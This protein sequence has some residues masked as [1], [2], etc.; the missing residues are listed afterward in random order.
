V[1]HERSVAKPLWLAFET[2]LP[3]HSTGEAIDEIE[4]FAWFSLENPSLGGVA[5]SAGVGF[6]INNPHQ[7]VAA[8]KP[9]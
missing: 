7:V 4:R 2:S 1:Q 8:P 6:R 5:R 3:K 9:P